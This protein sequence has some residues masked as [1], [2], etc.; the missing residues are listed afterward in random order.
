MTKTTG[1]NL[2]TGFLLA[3]CT[4]LDLIDRYKTYKEKKQQHGRQKDK[5]RQCD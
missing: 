3:I 4:A 5:G 1:L 2:L